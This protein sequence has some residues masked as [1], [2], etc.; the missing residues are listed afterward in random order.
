MHYCIRIA[1]QE[2]FL[3]I[4]LRLIF[5]NRVKIV[6][7]RDERNK[8]LDTATFCS[9]FEAT[10]SLCFSDMRSRDA[11]ARMTNAPPYRCKKSQCVTGLSGENSKLN[12]A[13]TV[14]NIIRKVYAFLEA[15]CTSNAVSDSASGMRFSPFNFRLDISS[16]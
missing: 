4:L 12:I 8:P 2:S 14:I 15:A 16:L 9:A 10:Q 7:L 3:L 1:V 11:H 6:N 13:C 5:T